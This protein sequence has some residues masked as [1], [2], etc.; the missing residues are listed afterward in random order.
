MYICLQKAR[1]ETRL[2]LLRIGL[3][4]EKDGGVMAKMLPVFQV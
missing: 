3:V 1:P 2:C 4:L